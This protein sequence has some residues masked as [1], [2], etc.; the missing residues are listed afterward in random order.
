MNW[1]SPQN[2][3]RF[4][5]GC[6]EVL[7]TLTAHPRLEWIYTEAVSE[8]EE[9]SSEPDNLPPLPPPEELQTIYLSAMMGNLAGILKYAVELEQRAPALR[10]F[11]QKLHHL[12]ATFQEEEILQFV[13]H[14]LTQQGVNLPDSPGVVAPATDRDVIHNET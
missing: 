10:A 6:R 14:T 4:F 2:R 5:Y 7:R 13:Q 12:A 3:L 1:F 11:A 8:P 9:L